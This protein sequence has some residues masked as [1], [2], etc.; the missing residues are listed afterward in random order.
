MSKSIFKSP[1][2]IVDRRLKVG[3][4]KELERRDTLNESLTKVA[5]SLEPDQRLP[6][7]LEPLFD[8]R[9]HLKEILKSEQR[10]DRDIWTLYDA[11]K[12]IKFFRQF[13]SNSDEKERIKALFYVFKKIKYETLGA[14]RCIIRQGEFSDGKVYIVLSGELNVLINKDPKKAQALLERAETPLDEKEKEE[15]QSPMTPSSVTTPSVIQSPAVSQS[16]LKHHQRPRSSRRKTQSPELGNRTPIIPQS[17][18]VKIEAPPVMKRGGSLK[19]FKKNV[20]RKEAIF[21]DQEQLADYGSIVGQLQKGDHFGEKAL[22]DKHQRSASI[23]S[24]SVV[25]LLVLDRETFTHVLAGFQKA[26]SVIFEYL[27]VTLPNL[28]KVLTKQVLESLM[29]V[30]D[31]REFAFRTNLGIE[32]KPADQLYLIYEGQCELIKTVIY[33]K[34]E[35]VTLATDELKS[36]YGLKKTR[37]EDLVV[38]NIERGSFIGEEICFDEKTMLNWTI[39]VSSERAKIICFPK[40]LFL[41]RCPKMILKGII[42]IFSEKKERFTQNLLQKL[43]KKGV[44]TDYKSLLG[45]KPVVPVTPRMNLLISSLSL[46]SG[47]PPDIEIIPQEKQPSE[48]LKTTASIEQKTS[49]RSKRIISSAKNKST[50]ALTERSFSPGQSRPLTRNNSQTGLKPNFKKLKLDDYGSENN[51]VSSPKSRPL[52]SA[53]VSPKNQSQG[54][55]WTFYTSMNNEFDSTLTTNQNDKIVPKIPLK[56]EKFINNVNNFKINFGKSSKEVERRYKA[57]VHKYTSP[58]INKKKKRSGSIFEGSVN[59]ADFIT[60]KLRDNNFDSIQDPNNCI[61]ESTLGSMV[62]IPPTRGSTASFNLDML[63]SCGA[64][65]TNSVQLSRMQ[66]AANLRQNLGSFEEFVASQKISKTPRIQSASTQVSRMPQSSRHIKQASIGTFNFEDFTYPLTN[67]SPR[68][69]NNS[70]IPRH[71]RAKTQVLP[72]DFVNIHV[73]NRKMSTLKKP[74][75]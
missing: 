10:N 7:E 1:M 8:P 5:G 25:E 71:I 46:N 73:T 21:V 37:K 16:I 69:N 28:E 41:F 6:S 31:V 67:L 32:G 17:Q 33:D 39:R 53:R 54:Q 70:F 44:E 24:N 60:K 47:F 72:K 59:L 49:P 42:K 27:S 55:V 40:K 11:F 4:M 65:P 56:D 74:L 50:V 64:S 12:E 63:K 66:S 35:N 29:Y 2:V 61:Y 3:E 34:S 48:V 26:K 13:I 22:F 68:M 36:L 62:E 14:Q 57:L 58:P 45:I 20:A 43:G 18:T 30:A 75:S 38:L 51:T 19:K 15:S 52:L 23:I 9:V